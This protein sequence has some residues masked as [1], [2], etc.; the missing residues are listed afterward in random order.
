MLNRTLI[1]SFRTTSIIPFSPRYCVRSNNVYWHSVLKLCCLVRK[2]L[3]LPFDLTGD[4]INLYNFYST[5][6]PPLKQ[7]GIDSEPGK[8]HSLCGLLLLN[9]E[10]RSCVLLRNA[11]TYQVTTRRR[12]T[13]H[14]NLQRRDNVKYNAGRHRLYVH[15]AGFNDMMGNVKM[16]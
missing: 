10:D 7:I 5:H 14:R 8:C 16:W 11:D 15:C 4:C 9:T 1:S 6:L 2:R 3:F 13:P 12:I